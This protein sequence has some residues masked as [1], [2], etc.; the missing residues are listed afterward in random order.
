MNL[1]LNRA[2]DEMETLQLARNV[3]REFLLWRKL[4]Y[5]VGGLG[6]DLAFNAISFYLIFYLITVAGIPPVTA[7]LLVAVPKIILIP[8]DPMVGVL[9]D[10]VRSSLG[11]RR[12]FLLICGPLSGLLFCMQFHMPIGLNVQALM[13]YWWIVQFVYTA[14][15][16]LLM[17]SYNAMEAELSSSSTERMQLVSMR[18]G[19]GILGTLGGS[20]LTLVMVGLLGGGRTGFTGMGMVFGALV[21][22]SFL[23]VF[24]STRPETPIRDASPSFRKE[25]RLTLGLKPFRIQLGVT[26][27]VTMATVVSNAIVVFYADYVHD[28]AD[29]VPLVMLLS[30]ATALVSILG[31]NWLATRWDRRGVF[32][33]GLII[34]AAVLLGLRFAPYRSMELLLTLV[35]LTGVGSAAMSI[36]PRAMLTDVIAFDRSSQGRSRAGNIVG[37]WSLGN[38]AGL[39]IGNALAGWL[40]ALV[41]Y[42]EGATVTPQL[43]EGLRM[44]IGYVPSAFCLGTIPLLALFTLSRAD[45]KRVE[46]TIRQR[47]R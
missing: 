18:Q 4:G 21:A 24:A 40:L 41:G 17:V 39:A 19:L 34:Q 36:F 14:N 33:I 9:T 37:L 43:Q 3:A 28:L 27:L 22:S 8:L 32:A 15:F 1:D 13:A 6:T 12:F 23:T 25:A 30:A 16:S 29:L 7:G 44:I 45:M 35:G 26:F 11:R 10:R 31:W 38:R 2:R 20:A 47:A 42:G 46:E 5:A